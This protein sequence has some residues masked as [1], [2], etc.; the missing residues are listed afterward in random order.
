[1]GDGEILVHFSAKK[2]N[3]NNSFFYKSVTDNAKKN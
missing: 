3:S 1:M 2:K